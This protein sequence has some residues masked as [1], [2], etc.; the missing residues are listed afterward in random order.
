MNNH[1]GFWWSK[2]EPHLPKPVALDYYW[3]GRKH[4]LEAMSYVESAVESGELEG[5]V[6]HCKGSSRCRICE[7]R[8]GSSE[9]RCFFMQSVW[10][11]PSGLRHYI[12]EHN[13]RPSQAFQEF[14]MAAHAAKVTTQLKRKDERPSKRK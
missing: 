8:N 1:E 11:W 7:E 2:Q 4:L 10:V 5:R 3:K 9:F 12:K 13:V 6:S 14:I